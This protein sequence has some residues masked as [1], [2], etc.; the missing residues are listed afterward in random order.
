MIMVL[1]E[2]LRWGG[3]KIF[4]GGGGLFGISGSVGTWLQLGGTIFFV[5]C[6]SSRFIL[7]P[8]Y[9]YESS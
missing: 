1:I 3:S 6:A 7:A 2:R 5:R 9:P 4:L 8:W